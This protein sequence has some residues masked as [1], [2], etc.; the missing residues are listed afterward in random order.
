[1]KTIIRVIIICALVVLSSTTASYAQTV[2]IDKF[3][4]VWHTTGNWSSSTMKIS[5]EGDKIIL[6]VKDLISGEATLRGN[7]LEITIVDEVN[8]NNYYIGSMGD[9]YD[10]D[11]GQYVPLKSGQIVWNEGGYLHSNGA[12]TGK[13]DAYNSGSHMAYKEIGYLKVGVKYKYE[14][15]L[16]LYF[17]YYS[18]YVDRNDVPIFYQGKKDVYSMKPHIYTNW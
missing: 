12:V 2:T 14:G 10:S 4:G 6:Q 11:D 16:E 15:T 18:D 8:F 5:K 9:F 1:M 3:L 17:S 7:C 13:Y